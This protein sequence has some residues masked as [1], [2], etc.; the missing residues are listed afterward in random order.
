MLLI[1]GRRT[2][3]KTTVINYDFVVP[4]S[5]KLSTNREGTARVVGIGVKY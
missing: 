5:N 4:K 2:S 1:V 3:T